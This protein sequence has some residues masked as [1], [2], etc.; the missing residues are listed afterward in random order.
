MKPQIPPAFLRANNVIFG[1]TTFTQGAYQPFENSVIDYTIARPSIYKEFLK[2]KYDSGIKTKVIEHVLDDSY[3]RIFINNKQLP[4]PPINPKKRL[5]IYDRNFFQ[6]NWQTIFKKISERKP[7][8]ITC[9]H[10]IICNNLTQFFELRAN[11]KF[12]RSNTIILNL[13][14]PLEEVYYMLKSYSNKFLAEITPAS[15]VS[16]SLGGSYYTKFQ[17]YRDLI[18]KMNL[19]YAFW[20]KGIEI[21]IKYEYPKIGYTNPLEE[22]ELFIE[23]WTC[24][25]TKYNK[26]LEERM[27]KY[28]SKDKAERLLEIQNLLFKFYPTAKDLFNQNFTELRKRRYWRL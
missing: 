3:Y 15:M 19:L 1:G 14:I 18:Y 17:Y 27:S 10:P 26:T 12:A 9:I 22:L 11:K 6:D 23:S 16:L 25:D 7:S 28:I 24:G 2:N 21:K 8:M 20:S 13:D 4:I 5:I